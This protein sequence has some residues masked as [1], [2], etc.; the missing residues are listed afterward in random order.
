MGHKNTVKTVI[1]K[2]VHKNNIGI[3][4]PPT[5]K[6]KEK[7]TQNQRYNR[8]IIACELGDRAALR[9]AAANVVVWFM[10]YSSA[11]NSKAQRKA[12]QNNNSKIG[13][14]NVQLLVLR[15]T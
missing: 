2:L 1:Q 3:I 11:N 15:R 10:L 5:T 4:L 12:N 9:I 8:C 13:N 14:K 7:K 6:K